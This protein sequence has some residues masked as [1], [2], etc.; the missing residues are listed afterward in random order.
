MSAATV[1]SGNDSS[2]QRILSREVA[3]SDLGNNRG[4]HVEHGSYGLN[5][6]GQGGDSWS[7]AGESRCQLDQGAVRGGGWALEGLEEVRVWL[8]FGGKAPCGF[9]N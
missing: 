3:W 6:R 1:R 2:D 9:L 7:H 5:H 4:C 8:C